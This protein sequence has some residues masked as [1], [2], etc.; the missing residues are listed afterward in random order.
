MDFMVSSEQILGFCVLV[1][2]IWAVVKVVKELN[3]PQDDLKKLVEQHS[4]ALD[5]D[6]KRLKALDEDNKMI[7]QA[8]LVIVN[9]S[10]DGNG[11]EGLKSTRQELQDYLIKR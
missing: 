10:V 3:K 5:N 4:I 11:I 2:S 1:T 7:L 9:H 8:L 6:N